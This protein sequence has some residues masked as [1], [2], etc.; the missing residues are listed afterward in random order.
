M[1]LYPRVK[2]RHNI[3]VWILWVK[4]NLRTEYDICDSLVFLFSQYLLEVCSY[5]QFDTRRG[6]NKEGRR[7]H[8][9]TEW[10]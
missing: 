10:Q 3:N 7:F 8:V 4:I 5:S 2:S 9:S 1:K 6:G